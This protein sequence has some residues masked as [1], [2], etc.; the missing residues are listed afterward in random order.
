MPTEM[1]KC[2][3]NDSSV[4]PKTKK[5]YASQYEYRTYT[6]C[7]Y[8]PSCFECPLVDCEAK[9]YRVIYLNA[10]PDDKVRNRRMGN[11]RRKRLYG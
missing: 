1:M 6:D 10:L 9:M 4:K 7:K 8:S 11:L 2:R 3:A 5:R